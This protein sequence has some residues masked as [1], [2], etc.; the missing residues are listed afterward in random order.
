VYHSI[1]DDFFWYTHFSDTDFAYG[2]ALGQTGATT[3][4]RL[5]GADL[6]PFDFGGLSAVVTRY[7]SEIRREAEKLRARILEQNR[8]VE[9][10]VFAA[11][12]DPKKPTVAPK[13]EPAPPIVGFAP[14]E[15]AAA[16]LSDSAERF[17]RA[18]DRAVAAGAGGR[19]L[20]E[21]NARLLRAERMLLSDAGLP[22][23]PWFKHQI[24]APGFYTG[25]GVKTLPAV[26]EAIEQRKW[27][28]AD[29]EIAAVA[30]VIDREADFVAGI[31]AELD[32][33]RQ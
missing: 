6:L 25:Y 26:R 14:L 20:A 9:E 23:R 2:R 3:V 22:G 4:M 13:I 29:D 11:I 10:G 32:R 12:L 5:A 24:Y 7:V 15:N 28:L 30:R 8:E 19:N 33:P 1:Y 21:A 18:F 17:D 31:A 27:K 16:K